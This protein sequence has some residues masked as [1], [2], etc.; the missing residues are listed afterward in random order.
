MK[1]MILYLHVLV[2]WASMQGCERP[3][4]CHRSFR[5]VNNT[6]DSVIMADVFH[7]GFGNC[8][9]GYWFGISGKD[10]AEPSYRTCLEDK[11][12]SENLEFYIVDPMHFNNQQKFYFCDSIELKNKVLKKYTISLGELQSNNFKITY[13]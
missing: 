10:E 11:L 5:F 9:L 12:S 4:N 7:D 2:L 13:P 1:N 3:E 6:Q 8:N